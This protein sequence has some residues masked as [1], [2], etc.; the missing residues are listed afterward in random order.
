MGGCLLIMFS[1]QYFK[2]RPKG[3]N[4]AIFKKLSISEEIIWNAKVSVFFIVG[5]LVCGPF[6][7][8][9][10]FCI[11]RRP[12]QQIIPKYLHMRF[13]LCTMGPLKFEDFYEWY[14]LT[15]F[16]FRDDPVRSSSSNF[17]VTSSS[18]SEGKLDKICYYLIIYMQVKPWPDYGPANKSWTFRWRRFK[19]QLNLNGPYIN[20]A[21][22]LYFWRHNMISFLAA[23]AVL[24]LRKYVRRLIF[25]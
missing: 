19:T 7:K 18:E 3:T 11:G 22:L 25:L 4:W 16:F 14:D 12:E 13:G 2:L 5:R 24:C 8:F 10:K 17:V 1:P 15:C 20:S 21:Q 9:A 6:I 23:V